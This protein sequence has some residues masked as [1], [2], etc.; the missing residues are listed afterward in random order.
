MTLSIFTSDPSPG[1]LNH[2]E[3]LITKYEYNAR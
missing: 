1:N 2:S 3:E